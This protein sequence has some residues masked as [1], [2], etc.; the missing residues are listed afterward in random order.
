MLEYNGV[1][2]VSCVQEEGAGRRS[3]TSEGAWQI[4]AAMLPRW[5]CCRSRTESSGLT[6]GGPRS[7]QQR[8][9]QTAP[10][11]GWRLSFRVVGGATMSS[12]TSGPEERS[13]A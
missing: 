5:L 6:S 9:Q 8:G 13:A 3:E 12:E 10:A 2:V 1:V 4:Y 7:G 11:T